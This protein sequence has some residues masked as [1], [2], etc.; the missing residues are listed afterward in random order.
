MNAD[1]VLSDTF[2]GAYASEYVRQKKLQELWDI[3]K[4]VIRACKASALTICTLGA[5]EG[6]PWADEVDSFFVDRE[7]GPSL[8]EPMASQDASVKL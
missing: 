1:S 8:D 4:A 5:Q 6:I 7:L 2:T 3:E